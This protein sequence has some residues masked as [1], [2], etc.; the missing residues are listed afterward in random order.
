M[1]E[2]HRNYISRLERG[3]QS[4]NIIFWFR[5]SRTLGYKLSDLI[6]EVEG[7]VEK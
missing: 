4:A 7:A 5:L 2:P 3:E 1:M 6:L